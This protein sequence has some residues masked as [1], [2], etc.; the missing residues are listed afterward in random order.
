[1]KR[2]AWI[3]AFALAATVTATACDPTDIKGTVTQDDM[4]WSGKAAWQY[5]M[6][7]HATDGHDETFH[8]SRTTYKH[9][10]VGSTWP[11]CR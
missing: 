10:P 2:A 4:V 6:T 11:T 7:V 1:V 9:C 3:A 8:T 5:V